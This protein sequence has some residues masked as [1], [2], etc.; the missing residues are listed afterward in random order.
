MDERREVF[1]ESGHGL[2]GPHQNAEVA[3]LRLRAEP[4]RTPF[5]VTRPSAIVGR[6]SEADV[7]LVHPE[8]SRRHCRLSFEHGEWWVYDLDSLNGMYVN[9]QRMALAPLYAGDQVRIGPFV[10]VVESASPE[11]QK[12][13]L[14]QIA[15]Q[16][17]P[18]HA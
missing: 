4:E 5:V 7:R 13:V 3:P 11:R 14:R 6:H 9:E 2:R 10:L 12:R 17:P 8:V 15:E 1:A 18:E 16:F